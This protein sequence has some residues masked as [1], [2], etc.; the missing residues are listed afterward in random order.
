MSKKTYLEITDLPQDSLGIFNGLRTPLIAVFNRCREYP[1]KMA[2]FK[3]LLKF[4]YTNVVAFEKE[5]L[6]KV[7]EAKKLAED[8]ADTKAR[9][10]ILTKAQELGFDLDE[11]LT[12]PKLQAELSAAIAAKTS[13][14]AK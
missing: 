9:T 11:R 4:M 8:L 5:A 14:T 3:G 12:T 10:V 7:E 13:E 6:L 2:S 1:A